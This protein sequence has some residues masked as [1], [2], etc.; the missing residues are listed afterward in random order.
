M[1]TQTESTEATTVTEVA[2][3]APAVDAET[4]VAAQTPEQLAAETQAAQQAS[5][6]ADRA[7]RLAEVKKLAAQ[8]RA[9]YLETDAAKR[10]RADADRA[11]AD[12]NRA[13]SEARAE[14]QALRDRLAEAEADPWKFAR[15]KGITV[16]QIAEQEL[17]GNTEDVKLQELRN[18]VKAAKEKADATEAQLRAMREEEKSRQERAVRVRDWEAA[19]AKAVG[20][21]DSKK[22]ELEDLHAWVAKQSEKG[23]G[24]RE[25]ILVDELLVAVERIKKNPVT[26]PFAADYSDYEILQALNARYEGY[27]KVNAVA[28][29]TPATQAAPTSIA[30]ATQVTAP[31]THAKDTKTPGATQ[32]GTGTA[33][34]PTPTLTNAAASETAS[35]D[36][37]SDFDKWSDKKQNAWLVDQWRKGNL[38]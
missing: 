13:K 28:P 17:A 27:A 8:T 37:P 20:E 16:Q 25:D 35:N 12:A 29:K 19:K 36:K 24:S 14:L 11:V 1:T 2:Q 9:R 32:T 31:A 21:F 10:S 26:A 6:K 3:D 7:A 4:A 15:S 38:R 5:D 23:G 30:S 34:K 18:E 33:Q 22:S